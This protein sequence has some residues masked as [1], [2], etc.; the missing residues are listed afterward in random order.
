VKIHSVALNQSL[1]ICCGGFCWQ[2]GVPPGLP[3]LLN[4]IV[5]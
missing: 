3:D 5:C 4:Q 2:R 1:R